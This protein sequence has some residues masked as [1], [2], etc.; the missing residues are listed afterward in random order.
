MKTND[1]R[2]DD[3]RGCQRKN[4]SAEAEQRLHRRSRE[5]ATKM[6]YSEDCGR[7]Q[8]DQCG[9]LSAPG[10]SVQTS[11]RR[12]DRCSAER[13][14]AVSRPRS[15]DRMHRNTKPMYT[16]YSGGSA[17]EELSRRPQFFLKNE[18]NIACK[19]TFVPPPGVTQKG[20]YTDGVRGTSCP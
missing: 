17:S 19:K 4:E 9:V 14:K 13:A 3:Q 5:I 2:Q 6:T 20:G 12:K 8:T 16:V 18:L 7:R 1:I 11:L 10:R 15:Y